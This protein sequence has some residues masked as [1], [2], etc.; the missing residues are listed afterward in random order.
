MKY[1]K[2]FKYSFGVLKP[3]CLERG[4]VDKSFELIKSKGLRIIFYK[5]FK[6]KRSDVKFLYKRCLDAPWFETLVTYLTSGYSMVYIAES[7]NDKDCAIE[8]LNDVTGFRIPSEAKP[9]TLR[10]LGESVCENIAHSTSN[11]ETFWQE[12]KHFLTKK[13]IKDLNL[14]TQKILDVGD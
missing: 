13:E 10:S 4:L 5:K 9:N 11:I 2:K 14:E 6:F 3:D 8:S 1:R 7:C 12:V